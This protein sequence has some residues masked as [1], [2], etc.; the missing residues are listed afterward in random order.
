MWLAVEGI[1]GAGKT[2]TAELIAEKTKLTGAIERSDDHPF[3]DAH[4]R[5][6]ER[7]AVETELAFMLLQVHQIRDSDVPG[8]IVTDFAPA[9][10][11]VFARMTCTSQQLNFLQDAEKFLWSGMPEPD[12]VVFLDVPTERCLQRIMDR[13]RAYERGI[14]KPVLDQ[15]RTGYLSALDELGSVVET[16]PLEGTERREDVVEAIL[17]IIG[18]KSRGLR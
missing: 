12:V 18:G 14:E 7:Y 4:Y 1:V 11:R 5:D 17:G 15:L 13:G 6:P 8:G 9:K 10:N 16:L 2:T 3:L